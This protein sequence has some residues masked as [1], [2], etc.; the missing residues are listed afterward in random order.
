M[1]TLQKQIKVNAQGLTQSDEAFQ[2]GRVITIS[3]GHTAHDIFSGF[4]PPMLPL[5]IETL[6]LTNAQAG[7]LTVFLQAPSLIQ[8]WIGRIADRI[9]LRDVVFLAPAITAILMSL[10]GVAPSYISIVLLLLLAGISSSFFHA[11]A[12]VMAGRL[13]G[14]HL[15]RGMGFFM[16]AGEIA[17]VLGPLIVVTVITYFGQRT[18]PWLIILGVLASF[19]LYVRLKD[20][21]DFP[22]ENGNDAHWLDALRNMGP[23]MRPM[24]GIVIVRGFAMAVLATYLPVFLR[25]EGASLWLAGAALS[26]FELSGVVGT[27]LGGSLSDRLGRRRVLLFSLTLSPLF[28]L[29]FLYLLVNQLPVLPVLLILG[30]VVLSINP[31]LMAIIQEHFT[32]N[33]AFANGIYMAMNFV[34]R[35]GVV[36]LAGALGDW[37]G[38][39]SMFLIASLV[40]LLGVPFVFF[41]PVSNQGK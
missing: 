19:V 36:M 14:N 17:R 10:L 1:E 2:T 33:R 24:M 25:E 16:V 38:L 30:F 15:G 20:V 6:S 26:V 35:S 21:P 18:M 22:L 39:R 4:L 3:A 29:L 34:L 23:V 32:E 5:L 37:L 28:M 9:N 11:V 13:S 8:P 27:F 12:P 41:L 7:L 40:V 31:V